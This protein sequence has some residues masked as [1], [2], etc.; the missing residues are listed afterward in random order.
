MALLKT[1]TLQKLLDNDL[2]APLVSIYMPTHS[3]PTPPNVTEDRRRFKNL[4]NKVL[5]IVKTQPEVSYKS[6]QAIAARLQ[7]IG[8]D[9]DFWEHRTLS[10]A[11]LLS[12]ECTTTFDLPIDSD[13]YVAVDSRFHVTPLFGMCNDWTNYFVLVVS[14]K[15]PMLFAGDAYGLHDTDAQLPKAHTWRGNRQG[16]DIPGTE[17]VLTK[18]KGRQEY[19]GNSYLLVTKGDVVHYFKAIDHVLKKS[20]P[21]GQTNPV[22]LAGTEEETSLFRSVSS[23]PNILCGHIESANSSTKPCMLAPFAAA[24]IHKAI[25]QKRH[26]DELE[27]FSRL[28]SSSERASSELATIQDAAEK[29]R[30]ETLITKLIR[31]TADT[32]RDNRIAMPKIHFP[33]DE[34]MAVIEQVAL[35]TWRNHGT[36]SL[37]EDTVTKPPNSALGAIFRY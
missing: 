2:P 36:I 26:Q 15:H 31:T 35:L 6:S 37:V 32:I 8:D 27:R 22:I 19:F 21:M 1:S 20:M 13:E 12:Q 18:R 30:I 28:A 25:V 9:F 11:I 10:V 7:A 17:H 29:G 24:F 14:K 23:Y 34:Q 16:K 33:T 4:R 5:E 3:T